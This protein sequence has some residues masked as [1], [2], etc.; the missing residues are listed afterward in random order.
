MLNGIGSE[1]LKW[2]LEQMSSEL[3][4]YLNGNG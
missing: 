3:L 2:D 4:K 1:L